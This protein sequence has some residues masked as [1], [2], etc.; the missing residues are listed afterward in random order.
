MKILQ[1]ARNIYTAGGRRCRVCVLSEGAPR[2]ESESP[3]HTCEFPNTQR[4]QQCPGTLVPTFGSHSQVGSGIQD[5]AF[6]KR[7]GGS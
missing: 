2:S 4:A 5:L 6:P 1:R 7:T 3:V